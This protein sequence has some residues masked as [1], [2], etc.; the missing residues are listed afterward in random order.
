MSLTPLL[1]ILIT[2]G[3]TL[4]LISEDI[5]ELHVLSTINLIRLDYITYKGSTVYHI[6]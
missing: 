6:M 4:Y 3:K 5:I 1:C 2:V